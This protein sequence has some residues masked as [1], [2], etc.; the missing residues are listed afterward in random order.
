MFNMAIFGWFMLLWLVGLLAVVWVIY[1]V[2]TKQ[3]AMPDIEKLIWV[4]VAFFLGW[5]G[6][7]IYYL[8]VKREGKYEKEELQ[9][10][11]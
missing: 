5:I 9:T 6:A 8:I 3:K 1:D 4:L 7:I 11:P 10:L 2:L